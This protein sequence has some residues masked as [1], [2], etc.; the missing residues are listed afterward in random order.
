MPN[1]VDQVIIS[2]TIPLK[3][4]WKVCRDILKEKNSEVHS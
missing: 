1:N 2:K 3:M 4:A